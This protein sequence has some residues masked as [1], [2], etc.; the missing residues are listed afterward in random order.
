MYESFTGLANKFS[1]SWQDIPEMVVKQ[2]DQISVLQKELL[3]LRKVSIRYEAIELTNKAEVTDGIRTVRANFKDR[4][5]SEIRILAEE[6]KK[7]TGVVAYLSSYDGQKVTLIVTCGEGT[8]KD[9]H[10]LIT[11]HL[12]R[13]GGRGGGDARLAQG[14]AVVNE[15]QYRLFLQQVGIWDK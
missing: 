5:V 12:A 9:A 6:M 10:Q 14:G 8:S 1:S 3:A 11:S 2:A 7:L 15:L 4:P 13:I